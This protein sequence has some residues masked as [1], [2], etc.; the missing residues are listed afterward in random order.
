VYIYWTE[1]GTSLERVN[2]SEARVLQ[3][4]LLISDGVSLLEE[5]LLLQL[6]AGSLQSFVL[7]SVSSEDVA[8]WD[9]HWDS[10]S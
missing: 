9:V 5:K 8:G 6:M 10:M 4:K 7:L 1:A 3:S 2:E